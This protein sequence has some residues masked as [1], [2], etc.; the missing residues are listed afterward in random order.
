MIAGRRVPLLPASALLASR[1]GL[2][3][4]KPA[5]PR[6][7]CHALLVAFP[8][9]LNSALS[10]LFFQV[11]DRLNGDGAGIA[12]GVSDPILGAHLAGVFTTIWALYYLANKSGACSQ[13][14]QC[15]QRATTYG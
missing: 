7:H 4:A 15:Q 11:D 12:L 6:P 14:A 13:C 8:G 10:P 2:A 5:P 3:R 1:F 9:A